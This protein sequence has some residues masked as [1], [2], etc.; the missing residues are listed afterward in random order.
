[1]ASVTEDV[2]VDGVGDLTAS[3]SISISDVDAGQGSFTTTVT[4]VGTPLGSLVLA[5]DGSYTYSV[6][7][8]A[9]QSLGAGETAIDTFTITALDGTTK[10][11][12]FTIHGTNDAAVIGTPSVASVTEDLGTD[13]A[14]NLTASGSISISDVDAGQGSFTTTVTAVGTPLGSLVL[15]ADGSY[16]YSVANAATQS[17]GAGE[18]AVDTFTITALD[19]TTKNISF[20]IHGTNDAAVIGT[21]S[22]ASV[23]EDLGT[24][25]AGNLTASGSVSISDV[26]AGQGSFTT[27]VTAVGTPLGSLV[28]AADGSY[29]YSV[30]NAATQSLGAGETAIDT[31]TITALDGTAKNISFTIHG[32]NDAAVIGTPSVASVTEDVGVDG[33]GNLTASGSISI[34]DVDAGQGSFTTTVTAVGT[35]L[36]SLVLAADGSYTYSVANAATQSLGAGETAIDT[37]TITALD[38][39]TKNISFTIHGT[40]D[41]AVIGTPSVASVTEDVGVDGV[42]DLTASGSISIS[43][44]DAGQGSFTT[45]VT[46]VGTPLGSLVLA[47]DGSYTYSVA[48]AATQSLGAGETAIDTFTITALDGTTKNISFTIHGTNDAAV[49]G[50]PSVA[51]VTEDVGADGVGN[52]TA[53]DLFQSPMLMR[54]KE[55]LRPQ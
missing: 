50:T 30:A 24:D 10:N 49:I 48:N 29:T 6:A 12:S 3:G 47:A 23:T 19:G 34:S 18:T 8:A 40:N 33:V 9:T 39:T 52:L 25:G 17:L 38:G 7:N 14:G 44:V 11:I 13:G 5:A 46:V 37:F 21:P 35:P 4:V 26:D 16:T 2:G 1:M 41:A 36:G 42:G 53:S 28:L 43:D 20:T 51:S 32:T 31:F 45:T 55:V 22:V 15:A 54:A 27:T